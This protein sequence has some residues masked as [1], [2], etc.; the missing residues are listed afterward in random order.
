MIVSGE[1][2]YRETWR[3]LRFPLLYSF[4][5]SNLVWTLNNYVANVD[6]QLPGDVLAALG[7]VIAIFLAF[8]NNSSYD[9]WWEARK[10]WGALVND[11]RSFGMAITSLVKDEH[12][13][14][15]AGPAKQVHREFLRRHVAFIN[16]L[17][18][19]LRGESDWESIAPYVSESEMEWYREAV[20]K[21]SQINQF[22]GLR[23]NEVLDSEFPEEIRHATIFQIL[24]RFYDAQGK[25][26]RIK[27]TTFPRPY[28]Y[29]T[30]V[31]VW[32]YVTVLPFS[33]IDELGLLD[34]LVSTF[35]GV[36]LLAFAR[37]ASDYE[38]PFEGT[39]HDI[40]M[41]ALCVTIER[42]LIQMLRE[43]DL[44]KK[45]EAKDGIIM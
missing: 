12:L 7:A 37:T 29:L 16:A 20:N 31:C 22:Q 25:C 42:D 43:T 23:L 18:M 33:L 45:V 36:L 27:N 4:F 40:S 8:R 28:V 44:P 15:D 38:N 6:F 11:S 41:T 34:I 13:R 1:L 30:D 35:V 24:Q 19:H 3:F 10:I 5:L 14:P 21:P 17:R 9:R 2:S 39:I 32:I 26:E